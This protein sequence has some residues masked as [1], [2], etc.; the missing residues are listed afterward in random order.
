MDPEWN[1]EVYLRI[2]WLLAGKD[3][4]RILTPLGPHTPKESAKCNNPS[5]ES[6]IGAQFKGLVR[7]H[8]SGYIYLSSN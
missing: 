1:K 6:L 7:S 8:T 5:W 4:H 3:L 2:G